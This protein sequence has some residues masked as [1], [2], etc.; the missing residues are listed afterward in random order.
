MSLS[1]CPFLGK[2]RQ[3]SHKLDPLRGKRQSPRYI[4]E[5]SKDSKSLF[6][7]KIAFKIYEKVVKGKNRKKVCPTNLSLGHAQ[8]F[9]TRLWSSDQ[10]CTGCFPCVFMDFF[11]LFNSQQTPLKCGHHEPHQ[12]SYMRLQRFKDIK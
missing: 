4:Q 6:T 7:R 3:L 12:E 5:M 8:Y 11:L 10:P 9:S 2:Q 1:T